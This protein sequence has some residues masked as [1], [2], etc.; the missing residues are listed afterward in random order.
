M[1]NGEFNLAPVDAAWRTLCKIMFGRE[2]G[3]LLEF[4]PYLQEAMLPFMI[5]KSGVSG[6]DVFLSNH[7]Y[8]KSGRFAAS[9]EIGAANA[10]AK[11]ISINDMK[12]IDSLFRAASENMVYCGNK[13][14]GKNANVSLA[15]NAIDCIDVYYAH[16]VRNVKKGAYIS[17]VRESEYVFGIPAF[18]KIHYSIR[19]LE[20]INANRMFETY[21]SN[22]C[23]DIYYSFNCYNCSDVIFGFNLR[24]KRHVIGNVQLGKEKYA[25]LKKK[26]VGEIADELA[27]EKRVFSISDLAR[28]NAKEAKEE[29]FE[30]IPTT[31]PPASVEKAWDATAKLVLGKERAGI[32]NYVAYL[33]ERA[34]PVRRLK[35]RFGTHTY[36]PLL[37]LV[38]GIPAGVLCT[39]E[40]AMEENKPL[41]SERETALALRQLAALVAKKASFTMEMAEGATREV[42]EIT[43]AIDSTECWSSW[44][45][46][47]STRS[48]CTTAAI[49]SNYVF[50][51]YFRILD[52]E[53]CINCYDIVQLKR[54]LEVDSSSRCNNCYYSHNLE[55]C[56]ECILCWN[57]KGLRYAVLNQQLPKEEY[58]QVKKLL[59]DYLN[60]EL[61]KKKKIERTIFSLDER[62]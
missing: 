24:G 23:S 49:Q 40:E 8:P 17:F 37:P 48:A 43:Q 59:L 3:G 47:T 22:F 14:F 10:K 7:L 21:Y 32:G 31:D 1:E 6:K 41:V 62:G 11:P 56:E 38:K 39:R 51:G 42:P 16:N 20:G 15:D 18:P 27:K 30:L 28:M 29:E 26:L 13:A 2:V 5:V 46:T 54:C 34:L 33:Q 61:D 44:D 58:W 36:K 55:G 57:A 53:F 19:C 45:A 25:G 12:D 9:D 60:A 52:S 50:G 4:E 35:G